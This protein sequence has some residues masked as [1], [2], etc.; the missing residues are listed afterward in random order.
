V[1]R[2]PAFARARSVLRYDEGS[3]ELI[4]AFKHGDRTELAVTL[5]SWMVRTGA[6]L[7]EECDAVVPVPLHRRRLF[8]RRFNQSAL[9]AYG[10][11]SGKR[12]PPILPGALQRRR[13]D[14]TQSGRS[15]AAR[16]ANV[17]SAFMVPRRYRDRLAGQQILL[18]DDV[19]ATGATVNACANTLLGAGVREVS[20][21]TLCRVVRGNS[22][23]I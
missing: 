15:A 22:Y 1:R 7:V 13:N 20:V 14:P 8:L 5:G 12:G 10:A 6:R 18:I 11:M 2:R 23:S 21:L 17:A 16:R 19:S 9:L 4:L 3:R